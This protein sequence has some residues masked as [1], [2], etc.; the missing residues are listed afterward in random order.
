MVLDGNEIHRLNVMMLGLGAP[1]ERDGIGYNKPD[2]SAMR[3]LAHYMGLYDDKMCLD[4]LGTLGHYTNTQLGSYAA[5]IKESAAYYKEKLEEAGLLPQHHR[6]AYDFPV[7]SDF[8]MDQ[9]H[10][11]GLSETPMF[12][13][14]EIKL[15][16]VDVTCIISK[17]D[18]WTLAKSMSVPYSIVINDYGREDRSGVK[19]SIRPDCMEEAV[20]KLKCAGEFGYEPD[21]K[22][23][24]F[25][26]KELTDVIS[27]YD[28]LSRG[29]EN[30]VKKVDVLNVDLSGKF[31]I[32]FEGFVSGINELKKRYSIKNFI[33]DDG[34]WCTSVPKDALKEVAAVL[35]K[36]GYSG[37]NAELELEGLEARRKVEE[38]RKRNWNIS[39]NKLISLEGRKLP[40]KPYEFQMEDA[41]KI[42]KCKRMLIGHEMGCG[43]TFIATLVGGSINGRKL[44]IVPESLRLNWK[45]EVQAVFPEADVKVLYSDKPIEYGKDWT[46]VGYTTTVKFSKELLMEKFPCVFID[47]AHKC[48]SVNN[49]G[50][51]V[52]KRGEAVLALCDAAEYCYPMT[53]TPIP[54]SNRDAYNLFKML[55]APEVITGKG[56]EFFDF[57]K[58]FCA[59]FNNGHGWDFTGSSNQEEL[60]V[61]LGK[62]MARRLRR[63]VLPDLV[64]QRTFIP[65]EIK[66]REHARIERELH[67]DANDNTY[68]ALAM[69]GR[70][71]MAPDK[72]KAGVDL[73]ESIVESGKSVVLVSG[74]DNALDL[75]ESCFKD[76]YVSIRGGMSDEAKQAAVDLFQSG[77]RQ[78]CVLNTIAG[79]VG[80]TLTRA[81]DMIIC[82]FDWTP[83]NMSQVE[84]RICRA[85]QTEACNIH[86]FYADN[87]T[88]DKA[89]MSMITEKSSNIDA[90]VDGAEN[91]MDFTEGGPAVFLSRLKSELGCAEQEISSMGEER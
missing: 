76:N 57:G 4:A 41:E 83:A 73:A 71:V 13:H 14:E 28:Q 23:K 15:P 67:K 91:T 31:I 60:N 9:V 16:M 45:R 70:N 47:E 38:E 3:F 17:N 37:L 32:R 20:R 2:W 62:Y 8:C 63:E 81:S 90:V 78:V 89:F 51:P 40:F 82:D 88:I 1:I 5:D 6:A 10:Y 80:L 61:L 54:T 39:S 27:R 55:K 64:K 86:Y 87:S 26:S 77:R 36:A 59:G 29:A 19:L 24:E 50:R 85:G 66:S 46:I 69:K 65:I 30:A 44:V 21:D 53:G 58:D 68:M 74:F 48:K 11:L 35:N 49:Y 75:A 84:D 34:K 43:K 72:M 18:A 22:L 79:G 7:G 42:I 12:K 52:A 25:I 56:F 33:G